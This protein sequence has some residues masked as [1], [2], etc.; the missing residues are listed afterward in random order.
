[1]LP[2]SCSH[3]ILPLL[4]IKGHVKYVQGVGFERIEKV[5][6]RLEKK[7]EEQKREKGGELTDWLLVLQKGESVKSCKESRE[8]LILFEK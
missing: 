8:G 5:E 4:A 7:E 2:F 6:E 3:V 1:M